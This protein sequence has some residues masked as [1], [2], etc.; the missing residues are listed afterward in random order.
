MVHRLYSIISCW[1][2][3]LVSQGSVVEV[4]SS[5]RWHDEEEEEKV[6]NSEEEEEGD[7]DEEDYNNDRC[8][9]FISILICIISNKRR[10]VALCW[11]VQDHRIFLG[12]T[13]WDKLACNYTLDSP[14]SPNQPFVPCTLPP[15]LWL[16]LSATRLA[17]PIARANPG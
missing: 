2:I 17:T 8:N 9:S 12:V 10:A 3:S 7:D 4:G 16:L 13:F 15:P 11:A 14:S 5:G 1:I 6:D